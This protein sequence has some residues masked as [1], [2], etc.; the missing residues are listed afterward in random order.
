[1]ETTKKI[2]DKNIK[3]VVHKIESHFEGINIKVYYF[4][5]ENT[6]YIVVP[7][8]YFDDPKFQK[9][10]S[11]IDEK[12]FLSDVTNYHIVDKVF[13]KELEKVYVSPQLE[14]V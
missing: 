13:D 4:D 3:D 12:S 5:I 2:M 6:Y 1:M 10:V 11:K 9:I 7:K 8:K 14:L